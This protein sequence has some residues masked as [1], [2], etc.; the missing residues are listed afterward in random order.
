MDRR[1]FLFNFSSY[2]DLSALSAL[3]IG[4]FLPQHQPLPSRHLCQQIILTPTT[5]NKVGQ[6]ISHIPVVIMPIFLRRK[7]APITTR[8]IPI[9]EIFVFQ[10]ST[11]GGSKNPTYNPP[12]RPHLHASA[13]FLRFLRLCPLSLGRWCVRLKRLI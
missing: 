8:I 4:H 9:I 7:A 1:G 13:E 6:I 12:S 10:Y 5:I 2:C 11:F 3:H